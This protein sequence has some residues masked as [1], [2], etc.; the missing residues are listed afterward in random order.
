MRI[1]SFGHRKHFS[2]QDWSPWSECKK[3][4]IKRNRRS[5]TGRQDIESNDCSN[6]IN[7]TNTVGGKIL[8]VGGIANGEKVEIIDMNNQSFT[9][10]GVPDFPLASWSGNWYVTGA[11]GLL[12]GNI[13]LICGRWRSSECYALTNR[14]WKVT[15]LKTPRIEI[16][17]GK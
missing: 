16:G 13:P 8:A 10:N 6:D 15:N 5:C 12:E 4:K 17:S 9:C 3:G 14:Q 1:L 11:G 7:Q 2:F